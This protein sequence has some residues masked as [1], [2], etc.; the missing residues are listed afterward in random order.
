MR[1]LLV[2]VGIDTSEKSGGWN[3]PVEMRNRRFVFVP[4]KDQAYNTSGKYIDGGRRVYGEVIFE[5]ARFAQE[6]GQADSKCFQLPKRLDGNVA[7]HLDPDFKCLTYGDDLP[8]GRK[9]IPNGDRPGLEKD[10]FLAFYSSFRS[11][12]WPDKPRS[13]VYALIGLF[14]LER[15]PYEPT[16]SMP[17]DERLQ[18][19]HTR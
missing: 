13:L 15:P 8:R 14:V 5:L 18:N 6:C 2:R 12:A 4:I 9:L 1:G 17:H 19:A 7:M 3:A 16:C 11:I 10:D